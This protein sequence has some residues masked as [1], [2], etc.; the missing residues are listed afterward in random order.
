MSHLCQGQ[1]DLP[2]TLHSF[3]NKDK[4]CIRPEA[5]YVPFLYSRIKHGEIQDSFLFEHNS[6]TQPQILSGRWRL[7][8]SGHGEDQ[9]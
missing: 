4:H 8:T 5:Q 1:S 7:F 6:I 9:W 2:E 3:G